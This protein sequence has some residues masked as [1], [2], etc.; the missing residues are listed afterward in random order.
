MA[1]KTAN[2]LLLYIG[3]ACIAVALAS[4]GLSRFSGKE[5]KHALAAARQQ[6]AAEKPRHRAAKSKPLS[7]T[8]PA[9]ALQRASP[10][11][12]SALAK[13]PPSP[14]VSAAERTRLLLARI[15][16]TPD[17]LDPESGLLQHIRDRAGLWA[18]LEELRS[19]GA[20]RDSVSVR[21]KPVPTSDPRYLIE[22]A[23]KQ[24]YGGRISPAAYNK[25]RDYLAI[26]LYRQ[27]QRLQGDWEKL[28]D[29]F[30]MAVL[31]EN[32]NARPAAQ[33]AGDSAW[34]VEP[35]KAREALVVD[36]YV[37]LQQADTTASAR[38]AAFRTEILT[39]GLCE[40]LLGLGKFCAQVAM[41]QAG[42][43]AAP[44]ESR[45]RAFR[46]LAMV[47][48]KTQSGEALRVLRQLDEFQ[49]TGLLQM[50][51]SNW[52]R[53]RQA[54][55]ANQR[56]VAGDYYFAALQNYLQGVNRLEGQ[57]RD[58]A[59]EELG[60]LRQEIAG[61]QEKKQEPMAAGEKR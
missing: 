25:A 12:D 16:Q 42:D 19:L 33:V 59:L 52:E 48:R 11:A 56:D 41:D 60:R 17:Q 15:E 6:P 46:A 38:D 35:L 58:T 27:H 51:R 54:A 44:P 22:E 53:A 39:K 43:E 36:R 50:A 9:P 20:Q 18:Y 1:S 5:E 2:P 40:A 31:R 4:V 55:Q 47:Y 57:E 13:A 7:E 26:A 10:A 24:L 34:M 30:A 28:D 14:A 23:R 37:R 45:D 61:Q 21:E 29:V 49:R 8:A 3:L 32:A